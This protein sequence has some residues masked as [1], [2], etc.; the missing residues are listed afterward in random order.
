MVLF[1]RFAAC[2]YP[3][4]NRIFVERFK[5]AANGGAAQQD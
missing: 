3:V 1:L 5:P 4:Q 2:V